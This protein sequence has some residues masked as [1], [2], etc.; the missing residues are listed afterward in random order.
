MSVVVLVQIESKE[1]RSVEALDIIR[2]SQALCL[3]TAGCSGFEILQ[4]QDNQHRFSFIERWDSIGIHKAFLQQLMSNE[5][6][7]KSMDVFI[8]GPHIEYFNIL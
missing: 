4:S 5:E 3:S 8:S 2:K 1:G 6:F 7:I